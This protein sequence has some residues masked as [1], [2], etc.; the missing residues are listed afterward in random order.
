MEISEPVRGFRSQ[1]RW[2]VWGVQRAEL[3]Q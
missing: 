3:K 2:K 1:I